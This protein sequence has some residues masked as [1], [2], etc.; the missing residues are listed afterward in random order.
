M[1]FAP[2]KCLIG[3]FTVVNS[4]YLPN[5]SGKLYL[6]LAEVQAQPKPCIEQ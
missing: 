2:Y 5:F 1:Q 3:G 4:R 6:I